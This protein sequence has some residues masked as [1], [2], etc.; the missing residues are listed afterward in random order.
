MSL[1]RASQEKIMDMKILKYRV[2]YLP[3]FIRHSLKY[4]TIIRIRK[5]ARMSKVVCNEKFI[6]RFARMVITRYPRVKIIADRAD[7][8]AIL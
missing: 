4:I 8:F 7:T 6:N 1:S 3:S 5:V 2:I